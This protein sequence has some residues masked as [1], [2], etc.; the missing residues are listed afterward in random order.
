[1]SVAS[2]ARGAILGVLFLILLSSWLPVAT[3]QGP[4]VLLAEVDGPIDRST[5]D[6]LREAI[7]EATAGGYAALMI[8]FDTPGGGLD[9]T[10]EIAQ[11][12]NNARDLPIL[13]W[14]GPVGAQAWSAG[15]I[16]LVATDLAAMDPATIIGSVQPVIIGP[17]GFEP[18]TDAKIVNA[19]VNLTR[20]QLELHGRNASLA[21]RFVR[22]NDNLNG[23]EALE[24]GAIE[25]VAASP[26]LFLDQADG[27]RIIVR[28]GSTIYKD[29]PPLSVANAE[30]VAFN[31]SVRVRFL[32]VLTD[33]L[34]ASL[35]LIL[36]IYLLVF[37]LTAPGYG[38]ELGAIILLLLSLVGLGFSVDPIALLLIILGVIL[39]VVE[40]K[41]PGF[42][43]FGIG[44][45]LMIVLGA[46]FLAR[47]PRFVVSPEYLL[48]FVFALVTPTAAFGGFLLFALYKVM[49][50]RRRKPAVG[51]M[52]G[53]AVRVVEPVGPDRKGYVQY[54]GELWQA[55]ADEPLSPDEQAYIREVDGILLRLTRAPPPP[56]ASTSS[57]FRQIVTRL[58]RRL[59]GPPNP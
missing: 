5:V 38:A 31:P 10:T 43:A 13:G 52:V 49:E 29:F 4:H 54:H 53:E 23:P 55:T 26:R 15:T 20:T 33:P 24:K 44:G 57:P 25:I 2:P 30:I 18:V 58:R 16:L 47:V 21:D 56:E 50:I 39:L 22:L 19:V 28:S 51:A 27:R 45:I 17:G 12:F 34:V 14:V 46:V 35:M 59:T 48:F 41:T 9:E 1:M 6:A 11:M 40:L 37:G 7:E 3:A 42:G 32:S 36:G 8:R